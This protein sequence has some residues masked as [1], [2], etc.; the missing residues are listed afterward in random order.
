MSEAGFTSSEA[1]KFTGCSYNQIRYWDQIDRKA[2][3]LPGAGSG[4]GPPLFRRFR[5]P[6]ISAAL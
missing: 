5:Q 6:G 1:M 3:G 4:H 2:T